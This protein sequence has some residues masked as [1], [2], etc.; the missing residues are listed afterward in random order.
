MR[1][2]PE[3]GDA[4][5]LEIRTASSDANP[6]LILAGALASTA[7]GLANRLEPPAA[8]KGDAY[9]DTAATRL[10]LTLSRAV[11][12]FEG[13]TFCKDVFGEVFVETFSILARN[14]EQAFLRHVTDWERARYERSV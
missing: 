9:R 1:I 12:A 2:P 7:D 13:S 6:Y 8:T 10:P 4:R 5:R 14:E 11:D 3:E